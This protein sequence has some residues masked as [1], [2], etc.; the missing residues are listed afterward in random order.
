MQ[1]VRK[2]NDALA[3]VGKYLSKLESAT[4]KITGEIQEWDYPGRWW[5]MI[6][7][8]YVPE[9]IQ[10]CW[11]MP[12]SWHALRRV[13]RRYMKGRRKPWCFKGT[14]G[15]WAIF[16]GDRADAL[17]TQSTTSPEWPAP[18]DGVASPLLSSCSSPRLLSWPGSAYSQGRLSLT[19]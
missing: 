7:R 13:M 16:A 11:L 3:Y 12:Q 18:H 8:K 4:D 9:D 19:A 17:V 15:G 5:G 6:G 2:A 1:R 14:G 10:A